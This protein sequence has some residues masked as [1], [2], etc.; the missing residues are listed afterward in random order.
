MGSR[1]N[2]SHLHAEICGTEGGGIASGA[3]AD[4]HQIRVA[5]VGHERALHLDG[6]A[7][8]APRAEALYLRE[9]DAEI[10]WTT[11]SST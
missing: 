4:H 1:I 5:F 11:R 2:D 7:R 9:A 10:N 8:R 3:G 6:G